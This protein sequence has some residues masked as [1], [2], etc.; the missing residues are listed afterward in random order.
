MTNLK[1]IEIELNN[2][3]WDSGYGE[4]DAVLSASVLWN[5][6]TQ[7]IDTIEYLYFGWVDQDGGDHETSD[8]TFCEAVIT[9]YIKNLPEK[10][11][12]AWDDDDSS[13]SLKDER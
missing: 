11:E 6:D 7:E 3:T 13:D 2:L 5:V 10:S 4:R 8:E 12:N 1:R 9:E